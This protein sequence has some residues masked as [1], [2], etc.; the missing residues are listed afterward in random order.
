MGSRNNKLDFSL[1][2]GIHTMFKPTFG[3]WKL[4]KTTD[5]ENSELGG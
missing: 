4:L 2:E 1:P 3:K 5:Q